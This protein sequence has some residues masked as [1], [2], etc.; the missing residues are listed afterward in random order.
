MV[1][2]KRTPSASPPLDHTAVLACSSSRGGGRG[3]DVRLDG[4]DDGRGRG[5][6]ADR[7]PGGGT[8]AEQSIVSP[9]ATECLGHGARYPSTLTPTYKTPHHLAAQLFIRCRFA[10]AAELAT[11]VRRGPPQPSH[12]ASHAPRRLERRLQLGRPFPP[13]RRSP[14]RTPRR[15][16]LRRSRRSAARVVR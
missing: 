4:G 11:K 15:C 13:P 2:P 14:N 8:L 6:C 16:W 9:P 3:R 10:E 5:R 12:L 7:P 1:P